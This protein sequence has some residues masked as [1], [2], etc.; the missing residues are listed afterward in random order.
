MDRKEEVSFLNVE[1]VRLVKYYENRVFM[2]ERFLDSY[3]DDTS[4]YT[5]GMKC[6]VRKQICKKK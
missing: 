5:K 6:V 1:M 4:I 2:L 3:V